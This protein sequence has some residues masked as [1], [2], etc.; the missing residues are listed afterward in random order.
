MENSLQCQPT[1]QANHQV[2]ERAQTVTVTVIVTCKEEVYDYQAAQKLATSLLQTQVTDDP[3][4][5]SAYALDGTL[6]LNVQSDTV[7]SVDGQVGLAIQARGVWVYTFSALHLHQLA[8]QIAGKSQ[9]DARALLLKQAGVSVVQLST[10][11]ELPADP[12]AIQIVVKA[13]PGPT[14]S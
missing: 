7:A 4:L 12:T 8:E 9:A 3:Q 2:G 5:G 1:I 13:P 14:T 11:G 6:V 10:T